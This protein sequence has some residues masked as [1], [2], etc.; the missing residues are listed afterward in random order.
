MDY[1]NYEIVKGIRIMKSFSKIL[2]LE[3][4]SIVSIVVIPNHLNNKL[5]KTINVILIGLFAYMTLPSEAFILNISF[6]R[7]R[8]LLL[9]FMTTLR[10]KMKRSKKYTKEMRLNYFRGINLKMTLSFLIIIHMKHLRVINL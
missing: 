6:S 8:N 7:L 10:F 9:S 3:I 5:S 1:L 2:R 4:A